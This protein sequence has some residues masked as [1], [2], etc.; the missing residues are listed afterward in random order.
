M[1][2]HHLMVQRDLSHVSICKSREFGGRFQKVEKKLHQILAG[3]EV[4]I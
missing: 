2:T 4:L 1:S 3:V